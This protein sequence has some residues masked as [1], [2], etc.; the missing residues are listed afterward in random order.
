MKQ[1]ARMV[2][3]EERGFLWEPTR[4]VGG[5]QDEIEGKIATHWHS[6]Y[7][8]NIKANGESVNKLTI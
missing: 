4:C 8:S 3:Q 2:I 6:T 5:R 1:A 7:F